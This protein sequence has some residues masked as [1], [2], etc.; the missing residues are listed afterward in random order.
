MN[1][2]AGAGDIPRSIEYRIIGAGVHGLSTTLHLARQRKMR[3]RRGGSNILVLDR[4]ALGACTSGIAFGV[5]RNFY[6]LPAI[7]ELV[8]LSVELWE[9]NPDGFSYKPVGHIAA[10]PR[11][12]TGDL[13][14]IWLS[15]CSAS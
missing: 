10:T 6:S 4:P 13:E 3:H 9:D 14:S 7:C 11:R 1:I 5:V 2:T 12:Q 8:K 15:F